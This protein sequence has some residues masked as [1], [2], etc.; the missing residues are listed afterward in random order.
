MIYDYIFTV[1]VTT[2]IVYAEKIS[3]ERGQVQ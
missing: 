3:G 1:Y 2:Y